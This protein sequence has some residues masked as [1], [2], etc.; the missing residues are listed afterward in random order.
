MAAPLYR[1]CAGPCALAE[2][3]AAAIARDLHEA[4]Q[5][6]GNATLVVSGGNTP[7]RF[8]E[9]LARQPLAFNDITITLAD[10]RWVPADHT[11]S[12]ERLLRET[13]LRSDA[14]AAKFIPLYRNAPTPDAALAEVAAD[15]GAVALPFDVVV[16]GM[17]MDGHCASLFPGGDNL[18][19]ALASDGGQRVLP[20]RAPGAEEPR[21][22]LTLAALR[23]TRAMYLHI[24]GAQKKDVLASAMAGDPPY[25]HA[26]IAGVLHASAVPPEIFYCP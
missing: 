17:G 11:R 18:Q 19:A 6:R 8:L 5:A 1:E 14:R 7:R 9:S 15:V 13:L 20:M 12:N 10:E 26:P 16:L 3:L 2:A 21:M 25:E 23:Q 22:T 4:L 24:E